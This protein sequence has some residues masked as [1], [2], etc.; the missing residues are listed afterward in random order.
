MESWGHLLA[1]PVVL[2]RHLYRT[3]GKARGSGFGIRQICGLELVASPLSSRFSSGKN[4]ITPLTWVPR[5]Y[6]RHLPFVETGNKRVVAKA[7][8]TG[9]V[10]S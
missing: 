9:G 6:L 4:K 8:V 1:F 7:G 3:L 10:G 5:Y 2:P